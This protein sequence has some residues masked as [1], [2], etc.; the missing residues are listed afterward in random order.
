MSQPGFFSFRWRPEKP[1]E[2]ADDIAVVFKVPGA[3]DLSVLPDLLESVCLGPVVPSTVAILQFGDDGLIDALKTASV[4]NA[5]ARFNGRMPL[6][7]FTIQP[8]PYSVTLA[9]ALEAVV[10]LQ[11]ELTARFMSPSG[12]ISAGLAT[13]FDPKVVLVTAPAGYAFRKPS[14]DRST[15]FI[16]AELALSTSGAVSFVAFAILQRLVQGYGEIPRDLRLLLVDTMNVAATAFSLREML[17]LAGVRPVPQVESFHSYGGLEE[18]ANPLPDTSLCIVSA[19]SSMNLHR[20]WMREKA[21]SARDIVTLV[22]FEDAQDAQHALYGLPAVTRPEESPPSSAYDIRIAGEYFFPVMEPPRKV[23]LTTTHHGCQELT[24]DFYF[25]RERQLFGAFRAGA[26]S[27]TRRSL[28]IDADALL[29]SRE[30]QYWVDHKVPQLLKAGTA[31]VIYQDDN[32]SATLAQHVAYIATAMGCTGVTVCNAKE[33]D[34]STV[35]RTAPL[36]CVAA[37]VGRGNALLS[38]SR[39]LRNYHVGARLYLIG[40]QVT[41]SMAK[42]STFDRNLTHSSHKAPI[43]V[44]RRNVFLS[45]GAVTDSFQ[46]ELALYLSPDVLS[47]RKETLLRGPEGTQLF[48]PSG[49]LLENALALNVDFAFWDG[50]YVPA[51]YQAEVLGTISTI[52][53]NARTSKLRLSGQQLR[54]PLLMHVALDPENFA[55]FNEGIIQAA[56]LRAAQPSELDYR[57]DASASAYMAVLLCRVATRFDH[58]QMATLEFLAAIATKRMQLNA[59]DTASVREAFAQA[60][61]RRSDPMARAVQFFLDA[62]PLPNRDRRAF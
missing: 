35:N 29:R 16:R 39:D 9:M 17:S 41:E 32:A 50:E 53:Q 5:L 20:K 2:G 8:A 1:A 19:S 6:L 47:D 10:P 31:Q 34:Q 11:R 60:S 15:Y 22:T 14:G 24:K 61:R 37:V 46:Q 27:L 56:L 12:W 58:P 57:G 7:V 42:L 23:L 3:T 49:P 51:A 55:R 54:S 28:F 43:D 25:L 52:L 38:L 48:L 33:V 13:I 26:E 40:M 44:M 36:V 30:F 21:L 4:K 59:D 45:S 18:V 62:F